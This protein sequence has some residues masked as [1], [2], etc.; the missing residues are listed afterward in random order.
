MNQLKKSDNF[1][2]S[3]FLN[4]K[5]L[6]KLDPNDMFKIREKEDPNDINPDEQLK[7]IKRPNDIKTNEPLKKINVNDMLKILEKEDANDINPDEQLKKIKRP[8][9]IKTNEPLKKTNLNDMLKTL[10]SN[11][12][13]KTDETFKEHYK[14]E[15]Q[16]AFATIK[17]FD[18]KISDNPKISREE[19]EII[20]RLLE[21]YDL[22]GTYFL[23]KLNNDL[24]KNMLI[25]I[26]LIDTEINQLQDE[27]RY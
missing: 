7:K 4:K 15:A 14:N 11:E 5:P 25:N 8:N 3:S 13:A 22:T 16:R 23:N 1:D 9:D 20:N 2:I 24:E 18:K 17:M 6:K 12:E 26:R 27:L 21:L 19:S 10:D